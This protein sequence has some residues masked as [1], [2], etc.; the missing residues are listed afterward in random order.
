ML[1]FIDIGNTRATYGFDQNKGAVRYGSVS[2]D[3]IPK[4]IKNCSPNGGKVRIN[5]VI[6]S[7]VPYIDRKI[8]KFYSKDK[9][10]FL[11]F[12]GK[13]LKIPVKTK[14]KNPN[15]L[16]ADRLVNVYGALRMYKAPVLV[17][18]YGTAITFDYVSGKGI[19]EGGLI[20]PGPE[21]AF[22]ALLA[23]AAKIP[24][25]IRL[26]KKNVSLLGKTTYDCVTS[27]VLC[28]YAAM[29]EGLIVQYKKQFGP[30]LLVLGTGGFSE[31]IQLQSKQF[32]IFDPHHSIKSLRLLYFSSAS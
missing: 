19:F 5:V 28:G 20:I 6:S 1:L 14:Y 29:T 8:R 23:R 10:I 24:K 3:D 27:G 2:H 26:P 13:D 17:I 16:G 32:D 7:V 31:H 9:H 21:I 15:Q 30:H 11:W 25:N 22:Q 4:L 18:D 12:A